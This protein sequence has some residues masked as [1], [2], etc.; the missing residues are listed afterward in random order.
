MKNI[1][2]LNGGWK[3]VKEA[4]GPKEAAIQMGKKICL[5]HTWNAKDGQDGGNDY[6]RG[7]CFYVRS[8]KRPQMSEKGQAWLEFRGA[9][10]TA[11]V[12]L[13]GKKIA[14]H[15]GGYSTF[16]ANITDELKDENE[17]V[18]SVDNSK[19]DRVYP[20]KADFT[21]YG[22]IYRDVYLITVDENHFDLGYW[23]SP[24]I[25]VTPT[26]GADLESAD[27]LVEVWVR[28]NVSKVTM[29][30]DNQ[31]ADAEA[32]DGYAR[33]IFHIAHVHLWNGKK[34][35]FLYTA[36]AEIDED[37]V[38][39]SFGCRKME[40]DAE[41]GFLLNGRSYPL[42]GVARHQDWEGVGNAITRSMMEE[43]MEIMMDMG[44]NT[45]R[46]AHY[47]H[48]QY[49]YELCDRRGIV[50]WAEIPYITE[51]M[52]NGREN[53]LTQMKELVVQNYNHPSIAC[54]GLSNEITVGGGA[55]PDMME[56]HRLLN[57]L[58][59]K[60]DQTRPTAMAHAYMLEMENPLVTLPDIRSYNLYYGWYI[61]EVEG[62][63]QWFDEFHKKFPNTIIGLSEYG[64]DAN[65]A[66]QA[67]KPEKGD[68]TEGYQAVYH[69]HLLKMWTE[70]PYI[71][72]MHC[73]NMFDF[74]A[75]GRN[76]GG[77]PGQNQKGLCTFDR[78]LKKDAFY[79][80]KAYLSDEPFVHLCG[81]RYTARAEE[82][83]TIKVYSNQQKITLFVDGFEFQTMFGDKV[84]EFKLPIQGKHKITVRSGILEDSMT[85]YK[86]EK[87]NPEYSAFQGDVMNWFDKPEEMIREGC[88]SIFD[89]A[90]EIKR[91][92]EAS[93]VLEKAM[94]IAKA[95][96]GDVAK[97]VKIPESVQRLQDA[98][99]LITILKQASK[100]FSADVIK[101]LNHQ[102]NQIEK[103]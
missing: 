6:Y 59:H 16:R 71:W 33:K 68:W 98:S 41:K 43:D 51:H 36:R 11:T 87:P 60:L 76:E 39:A 91:S 55:G 17:L 3:F 38:E 96:Y 50:V 29:T 56:N 102:L 97:N 40:W 88:Y 19:N 65:P 86:T 78:K 90:A 72:A 64:A 67:E 101:E 25:K 66:Y 58:C 82:L 13:N 5:P 24:A 63:D 28:G 79:I 26:L 94:E 47:Q 92:K 83:T 14:V 74:G 93:K 52:P 34:D 27:I 15:D 89:T 21:F 48:D 7:C 99:P 95:S 54:W 73:W 37:Y 8:L 4:A 61:G 35:P 57:E 75:D 53:T 30:V 22:G 69:E 1:M 46:L 62:N 45:I 85:V 77:K 103:K 10:M 32:V 84:F 81:K 70:R 100:A 44:V 80:Y 42:C 18:V 12:Y 49:F 2:A 20:Q 23:G 31:T 9:A